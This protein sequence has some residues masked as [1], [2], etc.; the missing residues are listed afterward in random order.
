[1][2]NVDGL[3]SAES[4]SQS[5]I[6]EDQCTAEM[7]E[8][9]NEYNHLVNSILDGLDEDGNN[10]ATEFSMRNSLTELLNCD[11]SEETENSPETFEDVVKN[12]QKLIVSEPTNIFNVFREEIF[13]CCVRAMRRQTFSPYNKIFVKFSD[14]E[15]TSEGAIDEGGPTR[16][17][18]RLV[19]NFIKDSQ[20]FT[21]SHKKHISLNATALNNKHYYEAGRIIA[22]S[23]VHGG[24]APHFFSDFLFNL[25]TGQEKNVSPT[26]ND[27]EEEIKSALIEL[28]KTEN[29]SKAQNIIT[30]TN[31]FSIAG[32]NFIYDM[33]DKSDIIQGRK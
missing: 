28:E 5:R 2:R 25:I 31:I 18:F 11:S 21:G 23:L 16:E 13:T 6:Q 20:M 9:S 7:T 19:I 10:T 27:V 1:M 33:K 22:L 30:D 24:P 15:G 32:Y 29:L 8:I 4:L 14:L 3:L 26:L 17:L 12:I